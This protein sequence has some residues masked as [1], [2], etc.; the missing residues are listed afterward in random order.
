[1]SDFVTKDS[2]VR[3][4][5]DSGMVRDAEDGKA[6][7]DLLFPIGVPF[8]EQMLTRFAQLM[9]RGAA[10]YTERN[11]EKA[12]GEEELRRYRSSALRHL[13][14][15][16]TGETDEDHAAAV[17]FNLLA[18]ETVKYRLRG[19][20]ENQEILDDSWKDYENDEVESLGRPY[21][22]EELRATAA[23][24]ESVAD[25]IERDNRW[26][27]PYGSEVW[28]YGE[29]YEGREAVRPPMPEDDPDFCCFDDCMECHEQ[30]CCA[31]GA[32]CAWHEKD[33]AA[34]IETQDR[35]D[36]GPEYC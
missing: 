28:G 12:R 22:E 31:G 14:Q 15:W 24:P 32:G 25:A 1:M 33:R 4:T 23:I 17:M 13:I 18:G 16:L 2:G 8:S 35:R 19:G 29:D 6:R 10:K 11:W 26:L 27:N 36:D 5:Y 30:A 9:E 34:K 3:Q 7:F 20:I 21:T